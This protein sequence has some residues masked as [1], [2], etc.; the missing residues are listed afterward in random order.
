MGNLLKENCFRIVV[1]DDHKLVRNSVVNL[2]KNILKSLQ[3]NNIEII[4]GSDGIELL[5]IIMMDKN[6]LIKYIFTDENMEFLNGSESV[7]ILRKLENGK[8]IPKYPIISI[9]AFDDPETRNNIMNSGVDSIL[10]KPCTKND[11]KKILSS[12]IKESN[13]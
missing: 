1:I 6:S 8:K 3:I 7:R 10:S 11:I 5:N 13:E 9:T 4:E 2:I 12:L